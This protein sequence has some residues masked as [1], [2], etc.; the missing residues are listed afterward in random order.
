MKIAQLAPLTECVPPSTYGGTELVVSLLTEELV[1]R[2]HEVTLFA[3]GS[4]DTQAELVSV[5]S[6]P[7][8]T[9]EIPTSRWAAYDIRLQLELKK[10]AG[11]FDIVHSHMGWQALS[12]L[13][14]LDCQTVSTNHNPVKD[15]CRDIY[16][17]HRNLPYVSI[18]DSYRLDN[19]DQQLNYVATIYNGIDLSSFSS[20]AVERRHLLFLGR[21]CPDKGTAEAIEI[22]LRLGYPLKIAGKLD[23]DQQSYFDCKIKPF[24][25]GTNIDYV[26]EVD[27]AKKLDLLQSAIAVVYPVAFGEP[28]GL[29]MAEASA[30]GI[31]VLALDRGA[32]K[33]VIADGKTGIVCQSVD[34]M[35][36]R[37]PE[38]LSIDSQVCKMQV[39][40][41]FSKERMAEQYESL[42]QKLLTGS[43]AG[44]RP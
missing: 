4:S 15:Y 39:R 32:V 11:R 2:G 31:P 34:E 7:L 37:F 23:S 43:L 3:C 16:L 42:Y 28:F 36:A 24:L 44:A 35:V 10:R 41:L 19:Y 8:R 13:E 21:I 6:E 25:D 27:F 29:V 5:I 1:R 12:L 17:H 40:Q 18:S 26:G 38:V 30:C 22:A 33:E 20:A 9:S 14:T